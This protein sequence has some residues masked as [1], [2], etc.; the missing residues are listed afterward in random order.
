M[1]KCLNASMAP[2]PSRPVR[3]L[4][5]GEGNFLRAFVDYMIDIANEK[6]GF[7]GRIVLV[8]PIPMGALL[9]YPSVLVAFESQLTA[10]LS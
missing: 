7:D 6:T 5:F 3:V 1:M 9:T 8:T 4:Q 2:A 10:A